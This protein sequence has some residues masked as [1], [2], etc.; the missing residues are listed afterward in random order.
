MDRTDREAA[1]KSGANLPEDF[2]VVSG[3]Q[4]GAD[5]GALDAAL[6]AGVACG[7]WCPA[8]RW[9]EDGS[10]APRYPLTETPDSD[11]LV[12]TR[13]NVA[14]ADGSLI[15]S[16][17]D[18]DAGT[19]ATVTAARA[20]GRPWLEIDLSQMADEAAASRI[21]AWIAG[22]GIHILNV[23]GPRESNAPGLQD[24]VRNVLGAVLATRKSGRR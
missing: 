23:A 7:G 2:R 24:R 20:L 16:L 11:P 4:T 19:R 10:I 17:G 5:R 12:R 3:G 1:A 14:D 9:A 8:D 15:L 13:R 6:D 18:L 21:A 22:A